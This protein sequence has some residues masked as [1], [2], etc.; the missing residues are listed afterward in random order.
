[1]HTYD[2]A[3]V[4]RFM[5]PWNAHDVE[6]AMVLMTDDCVWEITRGPEPHGARFEGAEAVRGAIANLF[7]AMP[8]IAYEL[9]QSS[10]GPDLV[11]LELSVIGTQ[12]DGR[13]ARFDACDVMTVRDGKVAAKRSYRKIVQ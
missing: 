2:E 3:F 5:A 8:D 13:T 12:A 10:F 7:E 11:V 6:G 9:V 4:K 1:M